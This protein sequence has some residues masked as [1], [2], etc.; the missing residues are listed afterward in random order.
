M[1]RAGESKYE[2]LTQV[3][4][5][6]DT[7]WD[8]SKK[9]DMLLPPPG[10][11]AVTSTQKARV[12][13]DNVSDNTQRLAALAEFV[14]EGTYNKLDIAYQYGVDP[15][16]FV[17]YKEQ[18]EGIRAQTGKDSLTQRQTEALL[19]RFAKISDKER[20]ALWQL[21][22]TSWKAQSNPFD[23]SVGQRVYAVYQKRKGK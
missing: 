3:G 16:V 5:D 21:Q 6:S 22:N 19:R 4:W 8:V 9:L 12:I 23:R 14:D 13:V 10:K 2:T 18:V 7:A 20:A 1:V 11:E 17:F 15:A